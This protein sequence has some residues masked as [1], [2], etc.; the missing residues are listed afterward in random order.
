MDREQ[1]S[2]YP[3]VG[4]G[5]RKETGSANMVN[6]KSR[7]FLTLFGGQAVRGWGRGCC[8]CIYAGER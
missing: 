1:D 8:V 6:G 3:Q 5:H 7:G 4:E 2:S